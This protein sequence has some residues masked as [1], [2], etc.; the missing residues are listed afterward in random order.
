MGTFA[1]IK[2]DVCATRGLDQ[3]VAGSHG[4]R[5]SDRGF[6]TSGP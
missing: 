5:G 4:Q 1:D 6:V 3:L 2:N